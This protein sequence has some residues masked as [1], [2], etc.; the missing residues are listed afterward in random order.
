MLTA[1]EYRERAEQKIA[2]T[3]NHAT[4]EGYEPQR[5]AGSFLRT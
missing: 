3:S 1:A 5:K 4:K 2:E